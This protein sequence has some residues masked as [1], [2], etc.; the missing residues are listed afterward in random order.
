MMKT[1]YSVARIGL[2]GT[3]IEVEVD[4]SAGLPSCTIVGLPD[5]A[6][7]E[8]KER[9][10]A[11]LKNVG[12]RFAP[13]RITVNLAP[14][15]IKKEGALYDLAIAVGIFAVHHP[16]IQIPKNYLFLGELALDG[17]IRSI[18]GAI[19]LANIAKRSRITH[20]ILPEKDAHESALISGLTLYPI[21]HLK[22]VLDFLTGNYTLSSFS[23]PT[24]STNT[25]KQVTPQTNFDDIRGH[26]FAKRALTLAAAGGHN[27]LLTGPP[28]AG[29][30]L[31]AQSVPAILPP[32]SEKEIVEVTE[33]YSI[34]G[35]LTESQ[36]IITT[37]PFR[38]PHHTA[39]YAS[40]VGGGASPKP[41]EISLAHRGVLFLD[42]LPEF[43]RSVLESLR[44][45]LESYSIRLSRIRN[46]LV[47]PACMM[48]IAAQNPCPCGFRFDTQVDCTCS[49]QEITRYEKKLSGP[50]LDRIDMHIE[51]PRLTPTEF[52]H[53]TQKNTF[54]PTLREQ[55]ATARIIQQN[56]LSSIG[57][58]TNSEIPSKNLRNFLSLN[59]QCQNILQK[60]MTHYSLSPR[61][62][63][64]IMKVAR[65]I[66]D[67]EQ[68]SEVHA[69]HLQ[70]ALQYR[71]REVA[72]KRM[73]L[74]PNALSLVKN[75]L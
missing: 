3:L 47:F 36:P 35:L 30:T 6:V 7:Q 68:K 1:V 56:R 27:I 37:R 10:R 49:P 38:A 67:I 23:S 22:Q 15:S 5:T 45:P 52:F 13:M 11:A 32:M 44:E 9:V 69:Q 48:L 53:S 70:E 50:F 28:G 25:L 73:G 26:V 18:Q 34:A 2:A 33:L 31:L 20:L 12:C 42:E 63:V 61:S 55:V 8:A 62:I 40:I 16:E 54:T 24:T 58:F 14:A 60:A 59:N 75:T 19:V 41:G 51:I 72:E 46:S 65:T 57:C 66:A 74:S 29:K 39:S 4:L 71:V 43:R 17:T 21:R 64:R